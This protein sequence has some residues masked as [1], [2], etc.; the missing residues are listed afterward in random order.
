MRRPARDGRLGGVAAILALRRVARRRAESDVRGSRGR[1]AQVGDEA[2]RGGARR[3]TSP[4]HAECRSARR[5]RCPHRGRSRLP[6]AHEPRDSIAHPRSPGPRRRASPAS[7]RNGSR[8]RPSAKGPP[9]DDELAQVTSSTPCSACSTSTAA[10]RARGL[11]RR[12][13]P[14][15]VASRADLDGGLSGA[16]KG[17]RAADVRTRIES[18]PRVRRVSGDT[19]GRHSLRS[20]LRC[21]GFRAAPPGDTSPIVETPFG[22][23]VIRLVEREHRGAETS[24][25]VAPALAGSGGRDARP[26]LGARLRCSQRTESTD[27]VEVSGAVRTNSWRSPAALA[28]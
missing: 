3:R 21:G 27:A 28:R 13:S 10:K 25:S 24:T 18:L 17:R 22:W 5:P 1:L 11:R 7:P 20:R 6:R 4:E 15:A 16:R 2:H 14:I 19:D 26:A 23:H 12:Q 8:T 9:T